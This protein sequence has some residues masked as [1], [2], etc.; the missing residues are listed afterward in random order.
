MRTGLGWLATGIVDY[1]I[2]VSLGKIFARRF[3]YNLDP[4]QELIAMG[5]ANLIGA[6]TSCYPPAGSLSRTALV[7][8]CGIPKFGCFTDR[9]A[10]AASQPFLPATHHPLSLPADGHRDL[11]SKCVARRHRHREPH[12]A[13]HAIQRA[14]AALENEL[15]GFLDIYH[16]LS[17]HHVPWNAARTH[18]RCRSISFVL[19]HLNPAESSKSV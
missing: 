10:H 2:T 8:N 19:V 18:W 12:L 7:A 11:H 1:A 3:N 4:N 9:G 16:L 5:G 6:F 14:Q 15:G 17:L 13:V